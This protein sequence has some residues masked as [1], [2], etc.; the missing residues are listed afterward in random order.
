MTAGLREEKYYVTGMADEGWVT[1]ASLSLSN[2]RQLVEI[3]DV[4]KSRSVCLQ[5]KLYLHRTQR[6]GDW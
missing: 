6:R 4:E 1:G 2:S 3:L 5:E